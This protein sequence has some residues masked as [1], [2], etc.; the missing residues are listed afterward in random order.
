MTNIDRKY[1]WANVK[2]AVRSYAKDPTDQHAR[3]VE[4]AWREVRR[5]DSAS[6][7]RDWQA[8]RASASNGTGRSRQ[9]R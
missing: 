5:T 1:A 2:S 6:R 3:Q 7:W 8:V 4:A 9:A